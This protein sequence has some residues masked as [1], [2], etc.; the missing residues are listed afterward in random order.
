MTLHELFT[1]DH[2]KLRQRIV[3]IQTV[4][5]KNPQ[6]LED[7]FP[8]F[9]QDVRA[10]FRKEDDVYYPHVGAG[11]KI[12]DREL[13]HA[14]RNDHAAV[15]FTLESLAIRLRKKVPLEEWKAK[16]DALIKVL[17]PHF[18]HEEKKLF[19]EVERLYEPAELQA[20]LEKIQALP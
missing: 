10:H 7:H 4:L 2:A 8:T 5:A 18:D 3:E 9:Q 17:L 14:L 19:P 11:K 20:L 12:A 16:F 6:K 13:I 1:A 15:V